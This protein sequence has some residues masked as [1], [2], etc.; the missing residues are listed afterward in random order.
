M[1]HPVLATASAVLALVTLGAAPA[2]LAE[3]TIIP[4]EGPNMPAACPR[5]PSPDQTQSPA[6][7][8]AAFLAR[9][10]SLLQYQ[11]QF[12]A[13]H[14]GLADRMDQA[15]RDSLARQPPPNPNAP[16]LYPPNFRAA[17]QAVSGVINPSH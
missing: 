5:S 14:Q 9:Q 2:A 1:R 15:R 7:A 11:Q 17:A 6:A 8:Q 3:P 4:C 10:A 12:L 16:W 13:R